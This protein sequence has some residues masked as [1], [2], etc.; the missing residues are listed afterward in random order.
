[1]PAT[2]VIV[3]SRSGRQLSQ[4]SIER[5]KANR[6]FSTS[7]A[8]RAHPKLDTTRV[9]EDRKNSTTRLQFKKSKSFG[10]SKGNA[11]AS[12][13]AKRATELLTRPTKKKN[14]SMAVPNSQGRLA[15]KA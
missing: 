11:A 3:S 9:P 10:S 2:R 12:K 4:G 13:A 15:V 5:P 7:R 14:P 8:I 6:N 1:M